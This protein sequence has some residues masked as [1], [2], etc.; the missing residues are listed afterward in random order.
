M[1][2]VGER[3]AVD[4][5]VLDKDKRSVGLGGSLFD[6]GPEG[7]PPV[8]GIVEGVRGGVVVER[9]GE[10]VSGGIDA[11]EVIEGCVDVG[12]GLRRGGMRGALMG[13]TGSVIEL[14]WCL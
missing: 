8:G 4:A 11:D 9:D 6:P 1:Q 14:C 5:R 13:V 7:A 2:L 12:L 10:G 3:L